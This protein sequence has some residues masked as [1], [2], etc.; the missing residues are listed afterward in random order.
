V[1]I[2]PKMPRQQTANALLSFILQFYH[3]FKTEI[4][5]TPKALYAYK[6]VKRAEEHKETPAI[7]QDPFFPSLSSAFVV[8][9]RS[10]YSK[11]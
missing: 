11:Y 4:T 1:E 7:P 10:V 2:N 6:Q 8:M 5:T 9:R 3:S